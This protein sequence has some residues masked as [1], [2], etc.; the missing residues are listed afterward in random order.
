MTTMTASTKQI[1]SENDI[2][3]NTLTDAESSALLTLCVM[4][5]YADG[6]KDDRERA[7]LKRIIEGLAAPRLNSVLI[8][9]EALAQPRPLA[10]TVARLESPAARAMAYEMAV[11]ICDADDVLDG[12]EKHFLEQLRCSLDLKPSCA[13]LFQQEAEAITALPLPVAQAI[14]DGP[15]GVTVRP[16]DGQNAHAVKAESD[17]MI[18]NYSI[19]NG[20]LELLPQSLATM[21]SILV[22]GRRNCGKKTL[23]PQSLTTMAIIPLQMKMVYRIGKQ[24]GF[25]LDRGHIRDF[26]AT[27][28]VGL[29]SQV[30]EDYARKLLGGLIGKFGGGSMGK[31]GRGVAEQA[32]SSAFSFASTYALGQVAKQYYAG[33]RKVAGIQLKELFSSSLVEAKSLHTRYLPQIQERVKTINPSDL[34]PLIKGQ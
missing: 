27:V 6:G 10:D 8:Y 16:A 4:A 21:A 26:L 28:D 33:G 22:M 9:K 17:K 13:A 25:E 20:A 32:T 7:E 31:L 5:A 29:T 19:L 24:H 30:V 12:R 34:L 3:P 1:R 2:I 18:L 15:F 23:L 14:D 11:C